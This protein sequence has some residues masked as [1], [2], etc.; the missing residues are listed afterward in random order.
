MDYIEFTYRLLTALGAGILIGIERQW[1][2]KA[3]GL[4]TNA[5]VSVGSALYVLLSIQLTQEQGDVT[6]IIGQIVTGVGFIGAGLIFKQGVN[7]HGLTTAATVWSTSAIGC[8]AAAG[9]Y[10]ETL[11]G[12]IVILIINFALVPIDKLIS[13]KES[14]EEW[15]EKAFEIGEMKRKIKIFKE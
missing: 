11:I 7:V 4:R 1:R 5:L 10:I 6:R 3:A 2:N 8:I 13:Q 9:F 14:K 15:I 12:V